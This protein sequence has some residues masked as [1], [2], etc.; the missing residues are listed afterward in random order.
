M[1]LG[2]CQAVISLLGKRHKKRL[3]EILLSEVPY[4]KPPQNVD[5]LHS[6]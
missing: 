4:Y 1:H 6:D 2:K 3:H 5:I